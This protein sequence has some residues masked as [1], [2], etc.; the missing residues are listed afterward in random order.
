MLVPRV[1]RD[2]QFAGKMARV[3]LNVAGHPRSRRQRPHI[4]GFQIDTPSTPIFVAGHFAKEHDMPVV[5]H[6]D[7]RGAEI[8][9]EPA[10][11]WAGP[12][13]RWAYIGLK[14][15]GTTY[16]SDDPSL[17]QG[18]AT[19]GVVMIDDARLV[20]VPLWTVEVS[21]HAMH[22]YLERDRGGDLTAAL[23]AAHAV[24]RALDVDAL[25]KSGARRVLLPAGAG[26]FARL[27]ARA[28]WSSRR[29][30]SLCSSSTSPG[31]LE[32]RPYSPDR[33]AYYGE[34]RTSTG[35]CARPADAPG[36]TR[37][38]ASTFSVTPTPPTCC[39]RERRCR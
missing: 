20:K 17:A 29:M 35:L 5:P 4:A 8:A 27:A 13:P 19:V 15:P 14:A 39:G 25:I 10:A 18:C 23:W 3:L 1:V 2:Q 26:A 31:R 24:A 28:M 33:T 36:S 7:D 37:R 38:P 11:R 6:P 16:D 21:D 9:I 32:R 22:R 12:P 34:S 30:G